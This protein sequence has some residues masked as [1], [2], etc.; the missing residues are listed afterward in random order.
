MK[1]NKFLGKTVEAAKQSARQIYA[2]DYSQLKSVV[3][4]KDNDNGQGSSKEHAQ[5]NNSRD[6]QETA[7]KP[8]K[9]V[10]FERSGAS[11][12]DSNKATKKIDSKLASIRKYA[13]QQ[14]SEQI[15]H[16]NEWKSTPD[17]E[18]L[19]K[20]LSNP[21][22]QKAPPIYSR[23]DIRPKAKSA[24]TKEKRIKNSSDK[25]KEKKSVQ[26]NQLM[27]QPVSKLPNDGPKN[28]ETETQEHS[29]AD[30]HKRLDRLESLMHLS[31]S[32]G[33]GQFCDHPLFH[34][35][36]HKGVPQKLVN[37]WF[38]TLNQQ[39]IDPDF[40]PQ[41]FQSKLALLIQDLLE[42][43]KAATEDDILLFCGRSGTGKTQLIMKL[44]QHSSFFQNKNIA[45]ANFNPMPG[46]Q[47]YYSVLAPYC[48][49]N[50]IDYYQVSGVEEVNNFQNR[51]N[52]Y[53]HILIDTP[54]IEVEG[55]HRMEKILAIKETLSA[56]R[57]VETQYLINTAI[58]G[59]A[60]NDPLGVEVEADHIALTHIDQS[61]KW[62][63]TM[64]LIT[65]TDYKLRY[66]SSG[67]TIAGNLLPFDPEKFAQK[68]IR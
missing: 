21:T 42:G 49:N 50:D 44:C 55:Q 64:Q 23:K 46:K 25:K 20:S 9:G 54:A 59:N 14:T 56:I 65:N 43:S 48:K 33:Y 4:D 11:Q 27:D 7:T 61:I 30:L 52:T 22:A 58:N 34:K 60:F 35:L 67:P 39:G 63:K 62:G 36:L 1:L 51:W 6:D 37:N 68:L 18:E 15:D 3:P 24:G 19:T 32:S 41:L 47:L 53:D 2:D 17:K 26:Q 38:D 5:E 57:G 31:L 8:N 45:V 29:N 13:A 66:I 12:A 16:S 28:T 40:R 10:V